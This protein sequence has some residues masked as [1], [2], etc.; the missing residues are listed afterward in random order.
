MKASRSRGQALD[1]LRHVSGHV[2]DDAA[3]ASALVAIGY[4][5]VE[6]AYQ[7]G[8]VADQVPVYGPPEER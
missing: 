5:L 7:V 6:L 1:A 4:A 8:R 3:V 2:K